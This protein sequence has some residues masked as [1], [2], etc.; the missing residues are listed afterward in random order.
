M[1]TD[2]DIVRLCQQGRSEGFAML[3]DAYQG[4]VYRRAFSFLR[5]REDAL[6]VTQEVFL[7][8]ARAI[9]HFQAGRPLWPW[10]RQVTTNACLNYIRDNRQGPPTVSWDDVVAHGEVAAADADPEH[11]AVLAWD[12]EMIE[13]AMA[14]LPPVQRMV[15]VLR[16]Q[17]HL[18]Y[19]E[20]AGLLGL[21][22]GTVK[23]HLF[24]ARQALVKA[25]QAEAG[26]KRDAVS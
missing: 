24:R 3:L 2:G 5:H 16:H 9:G 1:P 8:V 26:G 12:R 14:A 25:V 21:P 20:I 10:L 15:V 18:S 4:R 13:R 6:D 19:G 11:L 22:L 7:R 17:E 23:T